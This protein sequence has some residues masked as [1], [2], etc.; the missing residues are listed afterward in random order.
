[1]IEHVD[2]SH[3]LGNDP[4]YLAIVDVNRYAKDLP[5]WNFDTLTA[6]LVAAMNDGAVFAWGTPEALLTIRV[7]TDPL[8]ADTRARC[9]ASTSGRLITSGSLCLASYTSLTMCAQFTTNEFP[10]PG[11]LAFELPPGSYDVTVHRLIAHADGAQFSDDLPQPG[12]HYVV[13]LAPADPAVE[14][15]RASAIPWALR[16]RTA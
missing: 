15:P 2:L 1:V 12:D 5:D 9:T 7:T 3:R 10:Q 4:A 13:V 8:D 11:D 16:A 6:K 14:V